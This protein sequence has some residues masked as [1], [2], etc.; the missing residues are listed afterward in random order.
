[1]KKALVLALVL[2]TAFAAF[3]AG[4]QEKSTS[5]ITVGA[6][7]EPHA[8]MLNLVKEPEVKKMALDAMEEVTRD[9]LAEK[10]KTVSLL[11][12]PSLFKRKDKGESESAEAAPVEESGWYE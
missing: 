7:P 9:Y 10:G 8:E 5:K 4:A 1:M 12:L 3:A 11:R 2:V 6:T